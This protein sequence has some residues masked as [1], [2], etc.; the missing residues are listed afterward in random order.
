M[1]LWAE[2]LT[3]DAGM[4]HKWAHYFPA[5]ERHLNRFRNQAITMIEI[6]CGGGG[7]LQMWKRY[8]GPHAQ[9]VG[10][11]IEDAYARA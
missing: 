3:N 4:I 5:Y 10:I 11:D 6:G 9:L 7:S 8:L 2:F 1:S